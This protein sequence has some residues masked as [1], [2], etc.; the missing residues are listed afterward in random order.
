VRYQVCSDRICLP[1]ANREAKAEIAIRDGAPAQ[2]FSAPAGYQK[3]SIQSASLDTRAGG[4][5]DLHFVLLALGLGFAALFTPCVFPLIPLTVSYFL[6]PKEGGRAQT[7]RR[8]LLFGAGIVLFFASLGYAA[9]A[10]AGPF[11]VVELASNPWVNLTIA[12]VFGAIAIS[13]LGGFE[14]G[15]PSG[16]LTSLDGASRRGGLVG[17]T[18]LGLTFSLT[19]FACVGP[20]MGTLLAASIQTAGWTPLIGMTAFALGLA[21]PFV[22]LALFPALLHRL[23]RNGGWLERVKVVSGF[24]TL[25]VMFKYLTTA[26]QVLQLHLLTRE[27]FIAIWFALFLI[28][29]FYLLGLLRIS[30]DDG[31]NTVG[32]V[33]VF[34]G[35]AVLA[36]AVSILPG[37][38]G[39]RLGDLDAF[40]PPA[41]E[42]GIAPG[43]PG[44]VIATSPVWI[45]NRYD[46]ALAQAR[47]EGK[48]L[49]VSFSGYACTNCHWAK[50]NLFPDS[51]VA[52]ALE[53]YVRVELY[54]DGTDEASHRNQQFEEQRF[55]TVA[56]PF[57]SVIDPANERA[58]AEQAGL[59]KDPAMFVRFLTDNWPAVPVV[60]DAGAEQS[61]TIMAF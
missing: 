60:A 48:P 22:L 34:T 11:G 55:S 8:A 37:L 27:R 20:F 42:S 2:G 5:L 12:M 18:L 14:F 59:T 51:R 21:T 17:T 58:V 44:G 33:R 45:Q 19:S 47:R 53:N 40:I 50:A 28:T 25:A 54:T 1:P 16:L 41:T 15:L 56:L 4:T 36:F 10:V 31:G 32:L 23:P 30:G 61:V 39:G 7:I 13:M 9:S 35:V 57:Y 49:L 3:V 6:D 52:A 26:D 46:D 29:A 43:T 38:W 24:V